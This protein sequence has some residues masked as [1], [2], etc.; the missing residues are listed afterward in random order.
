VVAITSG[1]SLGSDTVSEAN[2]NRSSILGWIE[3]CR[4]SGG[5]RI[6]DHHIAAE[7]EILWL[8]FVF[9]SPHSHPLWSF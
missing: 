6:R 3:K 9:L 5:C 8:V 7:E 2:T 1:P 4:A